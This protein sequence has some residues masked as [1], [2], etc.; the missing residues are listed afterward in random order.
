MNGKATVKAAIFDNGKI[1]G[2]IS[3]KSININK[4]T[5]MKVQYN[6]PFSDRYKGFGDRTLVNG[7]SGS[8]DFNDGQWQGFEGTDMDIVIDL[9]S[10]TTIS[11]ISSGYMAA[12]GSWIF[13]PQSVEYSLSSD[14]TNFAEPQ[15]IITE[16][17]PQDQ[18][19][20]TKTYQSTF[21]EVSARYVR[22]VARGQITCP[23]WH[24][25]AGNKAWL[26][27]DEI[28]AE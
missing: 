17:A 12:V 1:M 7:I 18:G 20:R 3:S 27:C 19:N 25:G 21:P 23:P 22:V 28:V 26:F 2:R 15:V 8:G 9:G 24:A 4:A 13:L 11:S 6:T 10:E 5:A 14:G 16:V